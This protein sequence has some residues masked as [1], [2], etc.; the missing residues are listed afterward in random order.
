VRGREG[1]QLAGS[2]PIGGWI[3]AILFVLAI[4]LIGVV[5]AVANRFG[6]HVV[7]L[8]LHS[9]TLAGIALLV[10]F[11][12][13]SAGG[14]IARAPISWLVGSA[15]ILVEV[16]YFLSIVWVSPAEASL[17]VRQ[18]L[19]LSLAAGV[20]VF[21]R[22]IGWRAWLGAVVVA[23]AVT[24]LVTAL[25]AERRWIALALTAICAVSF[26]G[27]GFASEFHPWNR[28]ARTVREKMQITGMVTLVTALGGWALV[29]ALMAAVHAG[30]LPATTLLPVPA[31][32]VHAPTLVVAALVGGGLFVAMNYLAF[33]AVVKIG[34]EGL[35]AASTF[36]PPATLLL[37]TLAVGLGLIPAVALDWSLLP[38]MGVAVAGV[39]LVI[40]EQR[41]NALT[42]TSAAAPPRVPD[43]P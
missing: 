34:T 36:M 3:E 33:S 23:A 12:V 14:A 42:A 5:Y 31:D 6:T 19:P 25:P 43:Q 38:A 10:V 40:W 30:V 27:R 37:Q 7:A 24:W 9:M 41:R 29:G 35:V 20:L 18:A 39:M 4:G 13:G 15:N 17:L 32:F 26:V 28:A 22:R 1:E 11:G 21:R 8:M 16:F 2:R